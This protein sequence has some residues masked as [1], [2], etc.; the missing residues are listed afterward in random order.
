MNLT[1]AKRPTSFDAMVGQEEACAAIAKQCSKRIPVAF[2]FSGEPGSG[3]TSLARIVALSIQKDGAL[4]YPSKQEWQRFNEYSIIDHNAAELNGVDAMKDIA[5]QASF[6]PQEG[7]YRCII[8]DEA[9]RLTAQ[10]QSVL[11]KPMEET[12]GHVVFFF[13][14]TEPD[15]I[16][17]ALRSRCF[18]VRLRPLN[19]DDIATLVKRALK[20]AK[21]TKPAAPLVAAL[22]SHGVTSARSVVMATEKYAAGMRSSNAVASVDAPAVTI[23]ICRAVANG[24]WARCAALLAK[25]QPSETQS[26]RIAVMGYLRAMLARANNVQISSAII[27]LASIPTYNPEIV[28]WNH[29]WAVL[30]QVC[31]RR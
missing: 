13:C 18:D 3:K 21:S 15:K 14:T 24:D 1:I 27:A 28:Q 11:L 8:L 2:M 30:H 6:A 16:S 5:R 26:I 9:Q 7:R 25:C 4:G 12:T 19:G 17:K 20:W 22:N 31:Q 29:L 23:D 10:A